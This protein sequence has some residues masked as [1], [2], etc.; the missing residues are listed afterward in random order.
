MANLQADYDFLSKLASTDEAG[1]LA[2]ERAVLLLWFLRNVVGSMTSMLYEFVC[3]GDE[4]GGVDGLYLEAGTG[5]EDR[6]T[7]V[8]YQSEY[9]QSPRQ[10]GPEK[11]GR[12]ITVAGRF[13]DADSLEEFLAAGV[14]AK[15]ER[16]VAGST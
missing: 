1:G 2:K 10:V 14:E 4:D 8:I 9:T 12:L 5:D 11:L 7:L 6:E 16:L 3:D 13:K 15:L